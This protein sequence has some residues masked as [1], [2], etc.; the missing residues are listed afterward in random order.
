MSQRSPLPTRTRLR[1]RATDPPNITEVQIFGARINWTGFSAGHANISGVN[2]PLSSPHS[3][4]L[5]ARADD[6]ERSGRAESA[7]FVTIVSPDY[8]SHARA[9]HTS[10]RT[11]NP[12]ARLFVVCVASG[13]ESGERKNES[14]EII[15]VTELIDSREL[16]Y[17]SFYYKVSELCWALKPCTFEHILSK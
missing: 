16:D 6:M 7:C 2:P 5:D 9:L 13:R 11:H 14:F 10:L 3:R 17:M 15:P 8:L 1:V 4:F 12:N